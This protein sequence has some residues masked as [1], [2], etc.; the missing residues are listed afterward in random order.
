VG[1]RER[2]YGEGK[3]LNFNLFFAKKSDATSEKKSPFKFSF[4]S[5]QTY[6]EHYQSYALDL[7]PFLLFLLHALK[8]GKFYSA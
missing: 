4:L 8:Y 5:V 6:R 7:K 2:D 3:G 1:E